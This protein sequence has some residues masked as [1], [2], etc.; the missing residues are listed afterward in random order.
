MSLLLHPSALQ[1]CRS[2]HS[3]HTVM[4]TVTIYLVVS[5]LHWVSIQ[6]YYYCPIMV[7]S[8]SQY[9]WNKLGRTPLRPFPFSTCL[10][11][12]FTLL[13]QLFCNDLRPIQTKKSIAEIFTSSI[14]Y[15]IAA[16]ETV[17][18][19]IQTSSLHL[20]IAL[21]PHHS[22]NRFLQL[23]Q[24]FVL[25]ITA[26]VMI[27]VVFWRLKSI[28]DTT[29]EVTLAKD[30]T[31][32]LSELRKK[33]VSWCALLENHPEELSDLL[34][35]ESSAQVELAISY[36]VTCAFWFR[37]K[38]RARPLRESLRPH[39]LKSWQGPRIVFGAFRE[40]LKEDEQSVPI[41]LDYDCSKFNVVCKEMD[42]L[43]K[44]WFRILIG[45]MEE[46]QGPFRSGTLL[47]TIGAEAGLTRL[48]DG[49]AQMDELK[50][51][52]KGAEEIKWQNSG[53]SGGC[54]KNMVQTSALLLI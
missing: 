30:L 7:F 24:R 50:S 22:L 37:F 42:G 47:I 52:Q 27:Y 31:T 2:A 32:F 21:M 41:F 49:I 46:I 5:K 13:L 43:G 34:T 12:K 15:E 38:R 44:T 18:F 4:Y 35:H 19:I 36:W 26:L 54:S 10:S 9:C 48:I 51:C 53:H 14:I 8:W 29:W 17:V 40:C 25:S 28:E 33:L 16:D 11:R 6:Q 20:S 39:S 1:Y 3:L 45:L 23:R